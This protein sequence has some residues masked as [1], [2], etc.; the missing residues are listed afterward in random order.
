MAQAA[1]RTVMG[2]CL[3]PFPFACA[4]PDAGFIVDRK[5]AQHRRRGDRRETKEGEKEATKE[6]PRMNRG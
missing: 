6:K 2:C 3:P 1:I 4:Q 5:L